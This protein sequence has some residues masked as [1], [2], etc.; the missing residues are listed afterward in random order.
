MNLALTE[1]L[2]IKYYNSGI[3]PI[4]Y[5]GEELYSYI[6]EAYIPFL[7][8]DSSV[9]LIKKFASSENYNW[10]VKDIKHVV[11]G[12]DSNFSIFLEPNTSKYPDVYLPDTLKRTKEKVSKL[13][14][15][16]TLV[17]VNY[18]ILHSVI[19]DNLV[20]KPKRYHSVVQPHE[21]RKKRLAI[22]VKVLSEDRVQVIPVTSKNPGADKS[23]F[24]LSA[25]T[26]SPLAFYGNSGKDSWALSRMIQTVS[27][28]RICPPLIKKINQTGFETLVRDQAYK[29]KLSGYDQ[30]LLNSTLLS[31]YASE[32]YLE[33]KSIKSKY[34]EI[35]KKNEEYE[36]KIRDLE[37]Y[38][39]FCDDNSMNPDDYK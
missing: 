8:G 35:I 2:I 29:T 33:L 30:L 24:Q 14:P 18:G 31:A 25:D 13:L 12:K 26:L 20:K 6:K 17:E 21:M 19:K 5:L 28:T 4:E 37:K 10:V 23:T 32:D 22:V 16:N 11:E 1:R 38:K 34:L 39:K 36:E 7:N 15:R 3:E 27:I 9:F